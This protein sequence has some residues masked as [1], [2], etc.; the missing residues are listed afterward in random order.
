MRRTPQGFVNQRTGKTAFNER[1]IDASLLPRDKQGIWVLDFAFKPVRIITAEVDGKRKQLHYLYYQVINQTGKPRMFVPQFSLV[2][3]TGKRYEDTVIPKAVEQ[4]QNREDPTIPLL[5]AV[6]IMGIVPPSTKEGIDD[7][8]FGVA[9][10]EDVD[11]HADKFSVF[12]RGLSDGYQQDSGPDGKPVVKYKTL[13]IDFIRRGDQ[14]DLKEREIQLL[15]PPYRVGL[16]V[17]R[18]FAP[19]RPRRPG[20]MPL[21]PEPAASRNARRPGPRASGRS[22]CA[23]GRSRRPGPGPADDLLFGQ[24]EQGGVDRGSG[25]RP[26]RRPW[27]PGWPSPR[28]RGGTRAGNRDSPSSRGS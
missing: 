9:V 27:S 5:G 13:K 19:G 21:E 20:R 17:D 28:R 25:P 14:F 18:Y 16:L 7:A 2:T 23:S 15:D 12:V 8:V 22:N 24:V 26:R 1:W 6:N 4:I 10:W 3:D 11:P